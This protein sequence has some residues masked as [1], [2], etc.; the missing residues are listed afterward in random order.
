VEKVGKE[1]KS[2]L[3]LN[4]DNDDLSFLSNADFKEKFEIL[5]EIDKYYTSFKSIHQLVS[6]KNEEVFNSIL[7]SIIIS[8]S[9][10]ATRIN[11]YLVFLA[12][13]NADNEI[14]FDL[15]SGFNSESKVPYYLLIIFKHM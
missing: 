5:K 9:D 10:L 14:L 15:F 2:I 7:K 1:L 11:D 8:N 13:N 6:E 4:A 12:G 3:G